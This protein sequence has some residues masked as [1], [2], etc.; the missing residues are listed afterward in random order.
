MEVEE[1]RSVCGHRVTSADIHIWPRNSL[2]FVLTLVLKYDT[3]S[4]VVR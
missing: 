3:S 4:N 1:F 2:H